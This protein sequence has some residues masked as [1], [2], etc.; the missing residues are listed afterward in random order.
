[1]ISVCMATY[2]GARFIREQ[3][4]S[5]LLQLG[6]DD[7]LIVSDD[8]S[9]DGTLEIL[10]EYATADARVRVLHHEKKNLA[11]A[12]IKHSRNFY[13]A[14]DN[15]ENA[16]RQAKGDYIFLAD[17]D[18]VWLPEK[19]SKMIASLQENDS[20]CVMCNFSTVDERGKIMQ[21]NG[22]KKNPISKTIFFRIIKSRL[23]GSSMVLK[24]CVLEKS[25]PFPKF[26]LAHDL[27]LGCFSKKITFFDEPL[28]LYR[29]YEGN[30]SSGIDK[31]KNS[32][33]YKIAY[34]LQFLFFVLSRKW[35]LKWN[36]IYVSVF[37]HI[38]K[39]VHL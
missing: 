16:L 10:A 15:F 37:S 34:R 14:T 38:K 13:Y 23:I 31:S 20:D 26:L 21:K 1:M 25:L 5:I 35:N 24:K 22:L 33:L 4:D 27:W 8:G 36:Q 12:K 9:T 6:A 7:E 18:D 29:R 39:G 11:Y 3:I 19:K 30:V 17:Q 2:N 32:F 28:T